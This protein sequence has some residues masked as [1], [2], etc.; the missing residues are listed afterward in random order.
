MNHQP[1]PNNS[2]D[3]GGLAMLWVLVGLLPIPILFVATDSRA[4]HPGFFPAGL[5]LCVLCNLAGGIGCLQSVKH[6]VA[7]V[8]FGLLLSGVFFVLS[9]IVALFQACSHMNI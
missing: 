9:C 6:P 1:E 8:F 2:K 7:R 4:P 3:K 5:V